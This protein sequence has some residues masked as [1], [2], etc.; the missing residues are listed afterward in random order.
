MVGE[1][2][3]TANYDEVQALVRK[4]LTPLATG[5]GFVTFKQADVD[6]ARGVRDDGGFWVSKSLPTHTTEDAAEATYL[7]LRGARLVAQTDASWTFLM[8]SETR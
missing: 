8:A 5:N 2:Y 7:V 1:Q 3:Y 6:R 4:G